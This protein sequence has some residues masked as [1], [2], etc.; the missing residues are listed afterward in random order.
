MQRVAVLLAVLVAPVGLLSACSPAVTAVSAIGY[1][2]QGDLVGA[3]AVCDGDLSEAHLAPATPEDAPDIGAWRRRSSFTG[4]ESWPLHDSGA[5]PWNSVGPALPELVAGTEYAFWL[6]AP[7]VSSRSDFLF[8]D[9]SD[10]A[11]LSPGEVLVGRERP[12]KSVAQTTSQVEVIPLSQL[13]E[14]DCAD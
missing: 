1:D 8:F 13:E 6:Q 10:L 4:T 9:G 5:G 11:E 2:A 12:T 3:V 14:E 7:D